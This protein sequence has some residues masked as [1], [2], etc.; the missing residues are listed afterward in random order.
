MKIYQ[1]AKMLLVDSEKISRLNETQQSRLCKN[2][3][4]PFFLAH[5]FKSSFREAKKVFTFI[6]KNKKNL[7]VR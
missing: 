2:F 4:H 5:S 1:G 3:N 6:P 7:F